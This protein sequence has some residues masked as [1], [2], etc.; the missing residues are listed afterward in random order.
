M[1]R[2]PATSRIA[3][4]TRTALR[5]AAAARQAAVTRPC[6]HVAAMDRPVKVYRTY[7]YRIYPTRAQRAALDARL[8][9]SCDLYNAALE[10]RRYAWRAGR[11][12]DHA[13][14]CRQLSE[15]WSKGD[16]PPGMSYFSMRD[17]IDRLNRAFE[18]FRRR[19]AAGQKPGFPRF[20][21]RHRYSELMWNGSW[22]IV[23]LRLALGGIGHV[24]VRWH[25]RL[26]ANGTLCVVRVRRQL[27]RWYANIAVALPATSN[28][29]PIERPAVGVDLGIQNF[30]ALSTG[31]LIAG[32]RAY[33]KESKRLRMAQRRVARRVQGSSRQQKAKLK[34]ARR[35][36]RARNL[37]RDQAHQLSR[38]LVREFRRI[39]VE[40]LAVRRLAT[41]SFAK[42]INDQG[43]ALFLGLLDYKA[44]E[45]GVQVI[46]VRPAGTS[47]RCSGCGSSV[48][49]PLS[50]RSHRCPDCGL[51]VDRDVNAARNI[52]QLGSSCQ[53]STWPG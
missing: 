37:R 48:R 5:T 45:A 8:V 15:V 43:W 12:M 16:G 22:S 11:P 36:E 17:P 38:R 1:P 49:K 26:P 27:G 51:V 21:S 10:Q 7:R 44:E 20:R 31:E 13:T 34:V 14:Q 41:G 42:E 23:G 46:R 47:E 32:P 30:A 29:C 50:D 52:L 2:L 18:R 9:F 35:H 3:C 6:E 4:R 25:R 24:K 40:A 53:A 33:R 28:H 19:V 39:V